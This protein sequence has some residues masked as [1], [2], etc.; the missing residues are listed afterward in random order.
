M[1]DEYRNKVRDADF[2]TQY[3]VTPQ[4]DPQFEEAVGSSVS[5]PQQRAQPVSISDFNMRW[6]PPLR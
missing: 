1:S 2:K 3:D 5:R 4:P 6:L